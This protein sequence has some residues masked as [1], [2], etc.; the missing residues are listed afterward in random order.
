[1]INCIQRK[2]F[3]IILLIYRSYHITLYHLSLSY[4][5]FLFILNI[6]NCNKIEVIMIVIFKNKPVS[7]VRNMSTN[8]NVHG[9]NR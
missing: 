2:Y 8:E 1:M 7:H 9:T 4:Y 5:F 6:I 3:T